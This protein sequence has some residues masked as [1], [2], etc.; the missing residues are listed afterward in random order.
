MSDRD[1]VYGAAQGFAVSAAVVICTAPILPVMHTGG[2]G[3]NLLYAVANIIIAIAVTVIVVLGAA[4]LRGAAATDDK[5]FG[6]TCALALSA[7]GLGMTI[8]AF[9]AAGWISLSSSGAMVH[10]PCN[11][12]AAAWLAVVALAAIVF[13]RRREEPPSPPTVYVWRLMPA[14]LLIAWPVVFDLLKCFEPEFQADALQYHI[15]LPYYWVAEHGLRRYSGQLGEQT[16]GVL[17][18]FYPGGYPLL[19][20]MLYTIPISQGLPFAVKIVHLAF[21][22]A[23]VVAVYGFVRSALAG[24]SWAV[25]SAPAALT[26]SAMF[27]LFESV[28]EVAVWAHTDL[29]RAFFAVCAAGQM[30]SY[31]AS[32]RRRDLV[33]ASLIA[34]LSM[35]TSY[36]SIVF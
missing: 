35:S 5:P 24:Q 10:Q 13:R 1:R 18:P 34:G 2:L 29:A 14:L 32:G 31:A 8:F 4:Y 30:A 22:V 6:F 27:F 23:T 7:G 3:G 20:E 16:L 25:C 17:S 15:T 36:I 9:V 28:N 11:W 12:S 21:G 26:V 33:I 19:T